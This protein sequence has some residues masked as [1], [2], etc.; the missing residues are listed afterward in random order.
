[1][2]IKYNFDSSLSVTKE[3]GTVTIVAE[4]PKVVLVNKFTEDSAKSFREDF[5]EALDTGQDVIPVVIDS[6]GGYVDSLLS[7]VDIVKASPK[8]VITFA[9]GKAM[10]CGAVLFTCGERRYIAEHSRLMIHDVASGAWGKVGKLKNSVKESDRLN[11]LIYKIMEDNIGHPRGYL[12]KIVEKKNREDWFLT[13]KK[14]K[15]HNIATDIG[16]PEIEVSVSMTT[17]FK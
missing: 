12:S 17:T 7:M 5:A 6:Y 9:T 8:Q 13:A 3:K 15:K 14:A 11:D 10:S 4:A 2:H 16:I 1:M